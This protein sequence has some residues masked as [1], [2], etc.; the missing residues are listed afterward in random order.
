VPTPIA[1]SPSC[2]EGLRAGAGLET[3][4]SPHAVAGPCVGASLR[5][6]SEVPTRY[7]GGLW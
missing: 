6:E 4:H 3:L 7:E 2:L 5:A 1:C